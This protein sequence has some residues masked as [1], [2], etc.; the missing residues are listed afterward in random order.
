MEPLFDVLE[1]ADFLQSFL[2]DELVEVRIRA[3]LM[4]DQIPRKVCTTVA[5]DLTVFLQGRYRAE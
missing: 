2:L 4:V 3:N 5:L 1:S